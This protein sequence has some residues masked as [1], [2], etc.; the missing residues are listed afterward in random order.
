[1][2]NILIILIDLSKLFLWFVAAMFLMLIV[3]I[4]VFPIMILG[5]P[6]IMMN[7]GT[8][9]THWTEKPYLWY[10]NNVWLRAIKVLPT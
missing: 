1:M 5:F 8:N 10:F 2:K 6:M 9:K 3:F 7:T 4:P